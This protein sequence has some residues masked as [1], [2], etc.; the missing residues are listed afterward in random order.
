MAQQSP[1]SV[2]VAFTT[3]LVGLAMPPAPVPAVA[4]VGGAGAD[5]AAAVEIQGPSGAAG[6][7]S[8]GDFAGLVEIGGG[9][10]MYLECRGFGSPTVVLEAG[11]RNDADIWSVQA[12][13]GVTMVLPGVAAFT[14]V[15][16]YDRPGT[17]LDAENASRSDPVPMPRTARDIVADLH[18]LLEAAGVPGPYVLVGHSF[19]GLFVRLY[20]RTYPEQVAGLVLV[21]ALAEGV[22]TRLTPAQ[23]ALYTGFGFAEPP[24]GLEGHAGLETIDPTISFGQMRQAAAAGGKGGRAL[25]I[26]GLSKGQPFDLTLW[27]LLPPELPA[28]L[29][30]AWRGAQD[31]LAV[32]TGAERHTIAVDSSHYIQIA[33][34]ALVIAAVREV[35]DDVRAAAGR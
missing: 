1:V 5:A 19:G 34:P 27:E 20:E 13:P 3:L 24:P 16:A 28:A 32:V 11:Y 23:W 17:V 33:E 26:V 6:L 30:R 8:Q 22:E 14:R 7:A 12:E 25:P 4:A 35:V 21:D 9:R 31:E 15:C 29:E 10:R 18:A 2:L